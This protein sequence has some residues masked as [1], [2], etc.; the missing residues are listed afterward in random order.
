[1]PARTTQ[2]KATTHSH[3]TLPTDHGR[4]PPRQAL[5]TKQYKF[6]T[7]TTQIAGKVGRRRRGAGGTRDER[8]RQ[9]AAVAIA[10]LTAAAREAKV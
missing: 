2:K 6:A 9:C 8:Q 3:I 10:R 4:C 1:M 7:K 5:V